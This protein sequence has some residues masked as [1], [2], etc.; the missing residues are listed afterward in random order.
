MMDDLERS[1]FLHVARN[2]RRL[3]RTG[4]LLDRWVELFNLST[5]P[6]LDLGRFTSSARGGGGTTWT[7]SALRTS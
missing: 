1:G 3:L 4:A 7:G 5:A 2:R 6:T